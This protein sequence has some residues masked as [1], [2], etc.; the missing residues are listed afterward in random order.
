MY[1]YQSTRIDIIKTFHMNRCSAQNKMATLPE[2]LI[3]PPFQAWQM[4]CNVMSCRVPLFYLCLTVS[5]HGLHVHNNDRYCHIT[6][7]RF[8][9]ATR[10][11]LC[12]TLLL[13]ESECHSDHIQL[14]QSHSIQMNPM[15]LSRSVVHHKTKYKVSALCL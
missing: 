10:P 1:V 15:G 12:D 13:Q 6:S 8:Q 2:H 14:S 9:K 4:S 11:P 7:I 5:I 3:I